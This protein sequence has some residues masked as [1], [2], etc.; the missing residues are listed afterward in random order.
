MLVKISA[1]KSAGNR[2]QWGRADGTSSTSRT[3]CLRDEKILQKSAADP[4][5]YVQPIEIYKYVTWSLLTLSK[6][7]PLLMA[8]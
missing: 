8:T 7:S 3:I 6:K 4:D 5:E 1:V 2:R